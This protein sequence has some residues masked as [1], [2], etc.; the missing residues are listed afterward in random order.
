MSS[1]VSFTKD[2]NIES[3]ARRYSLH[4]P[5]RVVIDASG[6]SASPLVAKNRHHI[7]YSVTFI[8]KD[9]WML[10]APADLA[11]VAHRQWPDEWVGFIRVGPAIRVLP[12]EQW[13]GKA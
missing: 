10:A 2:P 4:G 8:R 1:L 9:G 6:E 3:A 11:F 7:G 13:H 12:I 5:D